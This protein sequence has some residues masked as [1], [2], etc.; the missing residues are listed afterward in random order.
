MD[1]LAMLEKAR[2][3]EFTDCAFSVWLVKYQYMD[4]S[5]FQ[6]FTDFTNEIKSKSTNTKINKEM[7]K[8]EIIDQAEKI[9]Q[10]HLEMLQKEGGGVS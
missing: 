6:S 10:A 9:R 1:G 5:N 3:R 7:T 4:K 8:E 2:E